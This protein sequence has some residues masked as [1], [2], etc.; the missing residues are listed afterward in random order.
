MNQS[1]DVN[2]VTGLENGNRFYQF[3]KQ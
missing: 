3:G 1:R 2:P